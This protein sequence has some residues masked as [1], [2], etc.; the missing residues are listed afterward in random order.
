M[1]KNTGEWKCKPPHTKTLIYYYYYDKAWGASHEALVKVA[2][3]VPSRNYGPWGTYWSTGQYLGGMSPLNAI[4]KNLGYSEWSTPAGLKFARENLQSRVKEEDSITDVENAIF[5][6]G[7]MDSLCFLFID[8]RVFI[9]MIMKFI[10]FIELN[11]YVITRYFDIKVCML[12]GL[13]S[14]SAREH[15]R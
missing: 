8:Q 12:G 11:F 2:M 7:V 10:K 1:D 3:F 9:G 5:D 13:V 4:W 6:L 14:F 15:D